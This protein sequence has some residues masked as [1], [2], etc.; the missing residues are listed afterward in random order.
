MC[1]TK[2]PALFAITQTFIKR[3]NNK[4]PN[5]EPYGTPERI[6]SSCGFEYFITTIYGL[7]IIIDNNPSFLAITHD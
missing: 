7:S 5:I 4:G 3:T 1:M 2:L 6:T